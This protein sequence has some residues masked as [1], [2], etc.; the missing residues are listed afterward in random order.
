MIDDK[1]AN[2]EAWIRYNE[3]HARKPGLGLLWD[4][5]HNRGTILERVVSWDELYD[6]VYREYY[7]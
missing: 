5:P 1:P 3:V 6:R 7:P 2:V 4:R